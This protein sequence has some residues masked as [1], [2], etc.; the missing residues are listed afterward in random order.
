LGCVTG[1]TEEWA[2][3]CAVGATGVSST[4]LTSLSLPEAKQDGQ[5]LDLFSRYLC[6]LALRGISANSVA[7]YSSIVNP[8]FAQQSLILSIGMF[9]NN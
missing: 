4:D 9:S 5:M 2:G 6:R 7:V 1:A 3:G 8:H